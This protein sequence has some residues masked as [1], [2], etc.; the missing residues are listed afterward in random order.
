M[1]Q[2]YEA[3]VAF[4]AEMRRKFPDFVS[5]E[6]NHLLHRWDFC[7][8]SAANKPVH[9]FLGITNNPITGQVIEPDPVTGLLPFRDLTLDAQRDIIRSCEKTFVG[10]PY[11]GAGSPTKDVKKKIEKNKQHHLKKAKERGDTY[12]DMICE[13]GTYYTRVKHHENSKRKARQFEQAEQHREA[14]LVQHRTLLEESMNEAV[15]V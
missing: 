7:F 1:P 9:Q 3:P 6:F 10:N 5:V 11:D 4:V 8:L 2:V 14:T 15:R 13:V 12:A